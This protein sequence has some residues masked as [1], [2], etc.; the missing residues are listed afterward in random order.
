MKGFTLVELAVV[1]GILGILAT[2]G[3]VSYVKIQQQS[4]D[5]QR[6]H[7]IIALQSQLEKFYNENGVYPPGCPQ[8]TCTSSFISSNSTTAP[9]SAT[10]TISSFKNLFPSI[11]DTFGDPVS[12]SKLTPF[13]DRSSSVAGYYYFGGAINTGGAPGSL[14]YAS[15]THMP[16]SVQ[17]NLGAGETSAY[18]VGYFSEI[19]KKW[20][21][22]QG[23]KG[24]A[25]VVSGDT[26]KGCVINS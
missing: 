21:L 15:T 10:T 19:H 5:T 14:S 16:C 26:A 12:Q 11:S 9:L 6:E 2:V 1:I 25:L 17:T 20:N 8:T 13:I 24:Q 22:F 4:H 7:D 3:A 18:I 23:Q